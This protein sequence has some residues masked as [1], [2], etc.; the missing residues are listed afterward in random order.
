M[1]RSITST[2]VSITS[3][4]FTGSNAGMHVDSIPMT[5]VQNWTPEKLLKYLRE[6]YEKINEHIVMKAE[7]HETFTAKMVMD[8]ATF[9]ADS[10][11]LTDWQEPA[12][13]R[14][15]IHTFKGYI[16]TL[17]GMNTKTASIEKIDVPFDGNPDKLDRDKMIKRYS[18]D[19]FVPVMFEVKEELNEQRVM[20]EVSYLLKSHLMTKEESLTETEEITEVDEI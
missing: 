14:K 7:K 10:V 5:G 17:T 6:K 9:R 4:D 3:Y 12:T 11:L 1:Y 15:I 13:V 8:E 2:N 18:T 16:L 20:S 19:T